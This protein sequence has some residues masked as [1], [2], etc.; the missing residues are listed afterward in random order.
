LEEM[1]GLSEPQSGREESQDR[2]NQ[3]TVVL[4]LPEKRDFRNGKKVKGKV[5]SVLNYFTTMP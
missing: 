1:V 5:V 3:E 4:N 2:Q